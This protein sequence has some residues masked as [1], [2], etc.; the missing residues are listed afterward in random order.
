MSQWNVV[1]IMMVY[2]IVENWDKPHG[3]GK[4]LAFGLLSAMVV[5]WNEYRKTK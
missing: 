2:M 5:A 4:L 3:F 1:Q